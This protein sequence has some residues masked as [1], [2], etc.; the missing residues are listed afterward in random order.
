[1]KSP[2]AES[3]LWLLVAPIFW[4]LDRVVNVRG[5]D[6]TFHDCPVLLAAAQTTCSLRPFA[7]IVSLHHNKQSHSRTEA[8]LLHRMGSVTAASWLPDAGSN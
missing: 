5:M 3:Y 4:L 8:T 6:A 2:E 1:M 7:S